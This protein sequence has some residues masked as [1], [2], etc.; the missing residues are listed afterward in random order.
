MHHLASHMWGRHTN[1]Q[2]LKNGNNLTGGDIQCTVETFTQ[3][4]LSTPPAPPILP[5]RSPG[6]VGQAS[7]HEQVKEYVKWTNKLEENIKSLWSLLWGQSSDAIHTHIETLPTFEVMQETSASL[8]L[9]L[10]L[11]AVM[12]NVQE[13]STRCFQC[14]WQSDNSI[15]LSKRRMSHWQTTMNNSTISSK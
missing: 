6:P 1:M 8:E 15:S 12:F 3:L 11:Q 10:T 14:T 9:L 13:Q 7:F 2:Q 5:T 4:T